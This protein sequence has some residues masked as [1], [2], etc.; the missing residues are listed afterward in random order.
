MNLLEK[1]KRKISHEINVQEIK[2][3]IHVDASHDRILR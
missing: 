1:I 2:Y 3:N